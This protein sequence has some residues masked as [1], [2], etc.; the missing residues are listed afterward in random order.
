MRKL[1][2]FAIAILTVT[3]SFAQETVITGSVVDGVTG[4]PLPG[5][6]ILVKGTRIGVAA[7]FD[8]NFM[9]K[10]PDDQ[11]TLVFTLI[12]YKTQEIQLQ[13]R[14]SLTVSLDEDLTEL[15]D[16]V[17]IGYQKVKKRNVSG[18]VSSV[19]SDAIE[20]IP[21]LNVSGI[22]ATQ[23]TGV[24]SVSMSGAPAARGAL[25]IRGSTAI[26]SDIDPDLAYSNPLYVIDGVQTSL[27][28]LAGYG[29]SNTDFLASL[30]PNDIESIDILKDA[31]AAAIYG[32]RGAN[33]VILIETKKGAVLDKPEFSFSTSMGIQP[34][35]DLVKMLV[36]AA[37]RR[38]KMNMIQKW[39]TTAELQGG[40]TPIMLS[41]SLNPAFNNNIDYQGLFY[42]TGV[43]KKYNFSVRGGSEQSNY[44]FS[45]GYDDQ[46][47]VIQAT[48][49]D[50]IT[51]NSNFNFKAGKRFKNQLITR[52]TYTDQQTGQGNP[53]TGQYHSNFNL[54]TALPVNPAGL[55]SSL[56]YV[57]EDRIKSITGELSEKMNQDRTLNFTL[58]NFASLDLFEGLS[59][60]SQVSF[61]YDTNKKNYYEP[62]IV[63]SAG[64]GF[65][66]YS[67][68]TRKN[69]TAENYFTFLNDF[70]SQ[71]HELTAVLGNR[72][73]YNQYEDMLMGAYGFGSDAIKVINDRYSQDEIFGRTDIR[74]NALVSFFGR[75][76][77]RFKNRYQVDFNYSMDGSSKFGEDNRWGEFYSVAGSWIVSD[78]PFFKNT[79]PEFIDFLRLKGSWGLTG[80]QA[81]GDYDR[82]GAYSLG[83]GGSAY[84]TNLMN[85]SSYGGVTGVVP[86]YNKIG[87]SMLA[88]EET[89]QWNVGFDLDLFNRRVSLNFDAYNRDTENL[90]FGVDLPAYSGY[91]SSTLNLAGV[92]NYGWEAMLRYH[93]FP[94]E[95]DLRLEL[96]AGFSQNKNYVSKLPNGNRDYVNISKDYG[97]VVGRP[98]NLYRFFINDYIIDDLS[99]LPINP[100]TGEPLT[101]KS[102]WAS[103][104]PGFPIWKDLNGDYLLDE[105]HDQ[106]LATEF[107]PI[108]DIQGSFNINMQYKKWYFQMYSQF[109]FGADI[110]NTVLNSYMDA[111]DRG[112][113]NWAVRG[114]ADLSDYT[115]WEQPGD[116]AAG[117][118]FPALYPSSPSL[119]PFYGFRGNQ[120]LWIDSGD[121]WKITNAS[122]GY[123]FDRQDDFMNK[124]GLSRLRLFASVLNPYQWQKSKKIVDA[125]MVDAQGNTYGNGYPQARTI[126]FGIDTRF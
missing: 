83:Y 124:I 86:N 9:L 104:R 56:F 94:R 26:G 37:E 91:N 119:G 103:I 60:N 106:K 61:V 6:N 93:V 3:F 80:K 1:F 49:V 99:Q 51:F 92:I 33:G 52:F 20:D 36:G 59:L 41:D 69:L 121:Y 50:R 19:R 109:S 44:R 101:G 35:P 82:F 87:N 57:S 108:P 66:S 27:E 58:S 98:L 39:W 116:G 125:S 97:Y 21:V 85:V 95:N 71:N 90:F 64:D 46:D 81:T 10:A 55:Q 16:V 110:K 25:V 114:L 48:G 113:D 65:A 8:G 28:D 75:G 14:S 42:K 15:D 23:V 29:V 72:V 118:D 54:N 22:I 4:A 45:L 43:A 40:Q 89:K 105:T 78:E 34:Q 24:Q 38:A 102:A 2:C 107:S 7:D 70:G 112:G 120:T 111:Y 115:F 96:M 18:A 32:S 123:T 12:G 122:V 84:W 76:T 126:S 68:Y 79:M 62:S 73:D 53:Y 117:V 74:A 30:N 88:W 31:S 17:L 63:R 67:L 100:F 11:A 47:G 77:Y 5:V 13:G